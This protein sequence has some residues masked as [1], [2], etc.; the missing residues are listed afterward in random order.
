MKFLIKIGLF[1]IV[2]TWGAWISFKWT[3]MRV[4]VP[5]DKALKV[6]SKFGNPLPADLIAVPRDHPEYKG[7]REELLGPG[8]YFLNPVEYD[9]ELV[10]LVQISAGDPSQWDWDT[11]GHLKNPASAPM[12]GLVSCKQGKTAPAG[13]EVV[14]V[15][16]RGIQKEVLTPGV[17]KLNPHVYEVTMVPAIVVPPGSVGVVTRLAGTIGPSAPTT[18]GEQ[19]DLSRIVGSPEHRGILKD[20]LQPGIYYK[21]PRLEKVDIVPVGYD[22]ITTRNNGGGADDVNSS[23]KFY[24]YD[25]YQVEADLTVVWGRTPMDAPKIVATVGNVEQVE[26]NVIEPAMKAACQNV[27]ANY[28]AKELIQGLTRS[29]FQD[30]LSDSLDKQVRSRNVHILLALLRNVTVKDK[31][32]QDATNGLLATIQRT[33]IEV[34]NQLTVKQK[35]QTATVKAKLDAEQKLVEV[36]RDTVVGDTSLKVANILADGQKKSAEI[37]AQRQLD[38][39]TIELQIANLNAQSTLIL[40]KAKADVD[41]MKNEA[42]AK[43]AEMLVKALG[44]PQ[45][46]NAYIFAKNFEPKDIKLIFAGQGTFWTDLKSFQDVGAVKI[47]QEKK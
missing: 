36:A 20:V 14:D 38:V 9:W 31:S 18:Q 15:G 22:A 45:A 19:L 24:S 32:G 17:Y 21:N 25:G 42:E 28:S 16:Y 1:L 8:R 44:T 23:L 40:G 37:D 26:K 27:G 12:M 4:Y 41:R 5:P 7:V 13:Q 43:G 11:N 35:T 3:V 47:L 33:N 2:I 29:K 39:A 34:E 10:D 30:E 6:I 46:Y